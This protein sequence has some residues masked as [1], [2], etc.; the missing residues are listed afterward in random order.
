LSDRG[1][2]SLSFSIIRFSSCLIKAFRFLNRVV[3]CEFWDRGIIRV[4]GVPPPPQPAKPPAPCAIR[5]HPPTVTPANPLPSG[6]GS[7][8]QPGPG[9]GGPPLRKNIW[10]GGRYPLPPH[11]LLQRGEIP[12]KKSPGFSDKNLV[13]CRY[14]IIPAI[15]VRAQKQGRGDPPPPP[16]EAGGVGPLRKNIWWGGGTPP[17]PT[18]RLTMNRKQSVFFRNYTFV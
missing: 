7:P 8:H 9:K 2:D 13:E 14:R 1:V 18:T 4:G 16:H 17:P 12:A 10:L 11:P 15:A 5:K 6:R 3:L